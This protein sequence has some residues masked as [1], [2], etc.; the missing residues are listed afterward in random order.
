MPPKNKI[1]KKKD[2]RKA[3]KNKKKCEANNRKLAVKKRAAKKIADSKKARKKTIA[4]ARKKSEGSSKESKE[5]A[6]ASKTAT[7]TRVT[8]GGGSGGAGGHGE[9]GNVNFTLNTTGLP[10]GLSEYAA[11]PKSKSKQPVPRDERPI[12]GIPQVEDRMDVDGDWEDEVAPK[13][14]KSKSK[15]ASLKVKRA[16]PA[17]PPA[18]APAPEPMEEA[19]PSA[20]P[21]N[22][23]AREASLPPPEEAAAIPGA[24]VRKKTKQ[25]LKRPPTSRKVTKE[26]LARIKAAKAKKAS[27]APS[28]PVEPSA[29]PLDPISDLSESDSSS[30]PSSKPSVKEKTPAQIEAAKRREQYAAKRQKELEESRRKAKELKEKEKLDKKKAKQLSRDARANLAEQERLGKGV[31]MP[32]DSMSEAELEKSD[33]EFLAREKADI[34]KAKKANKN[35]A[36]DVAK[37]KK[38]KEAIEKQ[39]RPGERNVDVIDRINEEQRISDT[40]EI[41]RKAIQ[42]GFDF[43]KA[44]EEASAA[45]TSSDVESLM[46]AKTTRSN[47]SKPADDA[48]AMSAKTTRSNRSQSS[49]KSVRIQPPSEYQ[50]IPPMQPSPYDVMETS[51]S[52]TSTQGKKNSSSKVQ[53]KK[54]R[55]IVTNP[56]TVQA[57]RGAPK[58]IQKALPETMEGYQPFTE[59]NELGTV[60]STDSEGRKRAKD[61]PHLKDYSRKRVMTAPTPAEKKFEDVRVLQRTG[62][63]KR[64]VVPLPDF[65]ESDPEL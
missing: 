10:P 23:E 7:D 27:P 17:A 22:P 63:E 3:G 42:S 34:E 11:P 5:K 47:R 14:S 52:E 51:D 6:T 21:F 57:E 38:A 24:V 58:L 36:K 39:R 55:K 43:D 49:K 12:T 26:E 60:Q 50:I 45:P 65:P 59:F 53:R 33:Q 62:T 9:G 31:K 13:P 28:A 61:E 56:T 64:Q 20:P 54:I 30:G 32:D 40:E 35:F 4:K 8:S 44:V 41:R 16:K 25:P 15:K 18:P 29:P 2:C 48:S 37:L 46:S 19:A 1:Q